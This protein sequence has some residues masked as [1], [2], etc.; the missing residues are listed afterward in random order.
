VE[1]LETI[2]GESFL[3]YTLED[4]VNDIKKGIVALKEEG[5]E[6]VIG[7]IAM[8]KEA[9][10]YGLNSVIITS[11]K[12]TV[13]LAL[14]EAKRALQIRRREKRQVEQLKAILDF[15]YDGIIALDEKGKI[16]VFNPVAEKLSGWRA[17]DAIGRE[18]TEVIPQ[19]KCQRLLETG[20][21]DLGE[22]LEIGET[23]VV[24]NRVP[25][26]VDSQVLGV[27]TTFQNITTLQSL[28]HKVRQRLADRGYVAKYTF[29]DILGESTPFQEAIQLA[30]EYALVHS[31]ILIRGETGCGKEMFAHAIHQSSS[32]AKG[33]FVAVNCAAL[34]E[35]LLES[36]L[37]GY[38]EGAFTGA[39]KGGKPGL[40]ELA[41]QGT[42]FLDEIGEMS[43]RL[44]ARVL[45]VL[46]EGEIMRLGDDRIIPVN[47][48]FI[49]A[50]HRDLSQM[51]KTQAFREDLYYR[52]N[53]LN[54]EIPPLRERGADVLLLAEH[55]LKEIAR[56]LNRQTP[57][58]SQ[59]A[60]E[61]LFRYSWP[62]NVRELKNAVE[63]LLLRCRSPKVEAV[64]IA[65]V[66]KI[67]LE[68]K[69]PQEAA[70]SQKEKE[71]L[72]NQVDTI[73]LSLI[74]RTL[75]ECGGNKAEAARRL[76][77]SRTTLWRKLKA[78]EK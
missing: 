42:I 36:E 72:N 41:H 6:V 53:V 51:I 7:K 56:E 58:F 52:L 17:E 3:K 21:P 11:G 64:D 9:R 43:P 18:V 27:V 22:L 69:S 71:N 40:F 49:A 45:R 35:N 50:T 25:I 44:Q 13:Y 2:L 28:E 39:R 74:K 31:T 77:V 66:L 8:A 4:Q 19:A 15:A 29:N 54:L 73:T 26:V 78:A 14:K 12:E 67:D 61:V 5:A 55:F 34:P 65:S 48:R 16:T 62:G 70:E 37:F 59:E 68:E 10:N 47:V 20:K 60:I 23:K 57:K 33:P 1:S 46:E 24:A 75:A 63:R 38:A 76:G 30:K 32:R